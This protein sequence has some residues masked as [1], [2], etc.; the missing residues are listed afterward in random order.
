MLS[1]LIFLFAPERLTN[2]FQ[3]T[4]AH[5]F[6]WPLSIG[7]SI[8]LVARTPPQTEVV[9]RSQYDQLRNHLANVIE[10]RDQEH[11]KVEQLSGLRVIPAWERMNFVL[12]DII[13]A[14]ERLQNELIINRGEEDGLGVGQFV[15]GDNSIIGTISGVSLRAARVRLF[16]NPASKIAV[17]IDGASAGRLMQGC[18]DNSAKVRMLKDRVRVGTEVMASKKP[19][20]LD[21]AM[22]IGRVTQCR[23]NDESPL[24]W[25]VEVE[26]VCDIEKLN[27]V[28]VIVMNSQKR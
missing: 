24:L 7:R 27:S 1:G 8:T 9:S 15:L 3:F 28:A 2:R 22:I 10:Q 6:R 23:R 11:K 18:G 12:A 16:T 4:F 13:T 20:F 21:T 26:P 17:K 5:L 25:D 14:R 19:G